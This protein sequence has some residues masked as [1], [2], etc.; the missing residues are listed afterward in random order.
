MKRSGRDQDCLVC[1]I[2]SHGHEDGM[3]C[4]KEGSVSLEELCEFFNSKN[5]PVLAGK[6]KIFLTSVSLLFLVFFLQESE[7]FYSFRKYLN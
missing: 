5:C 6:P 2:I 1:A 4:C 3:I 7:T